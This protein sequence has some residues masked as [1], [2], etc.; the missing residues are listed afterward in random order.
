[1]LSKA[2]VSQSKIL[3]MIATLVATM[4]LSVFASTTAS[5][6]GGSYRQNVYSLGDSVAAGFGA[7][8]IA[9]SPF[10]TPCERTTAAHNDVI[11][12]NTG[13]SG[14]NLSCSGATA[15]QGLLG[16]QTRNGETI[17]RQLAQLFFLQQRPTLMT[18]SIGANDVNYVDFL[19]LCLLPNTPENPGCDTPENTAVF[20]ALLTAAKPKINLSV[21]LM[22][23]KK[24][25]HFAITGYYDPFGATAPAFGL[26]AGEIAWYQ[27]R[28][29]DV[30]A[31]LA[32]IASDRG[33][34]Y[35]DTSS[36]DGAAGD[37]ILGNPLTTYGFAHP[38]PQGQSKIADLI[39]NE[40]GL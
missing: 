6:T 7:G 26:S 25:K 19:G 2:N 21:A 17:P 24:P 31:V 38:T 9:S 12:A 3:I 20:N 28:T 30:N 37:V 33:V 1:M 10:A 13:L 14:T 22:K 32:D 35:I 36:L 39:T 40:F 5:A 15:L 34:T 8:P 4:L 27:A 23:F 16:K 29:A 18:L 11:S